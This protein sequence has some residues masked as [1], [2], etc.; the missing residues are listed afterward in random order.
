MQRL[1]E[2]KPSSLVSL[3]MRPKRSSR[4][5]ARLGFGLSLCICLGEVPGEAEVTAAPQRGLY[6]A[7]AAATRE[8]AEQLPRAP[9]S[10]SGGDLRSLEWSRLQARSSADMQK[11]RRRSDVELKDRVFDGF[12]TGFSWFRSVDGAFLSLRDGI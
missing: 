12:L 8:V 5:N 9:Q 1:L 4:S 10:T 11:E 7:T 6:G 3:F 2:V